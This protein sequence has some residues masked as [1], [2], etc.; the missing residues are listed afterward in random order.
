MNLI[1]VVEHEIKNGGMI[2]SVLAMSNH[3][4]GQFNV[5]LICPPNSFLITEKLNPAITVIP[6]K[7]E[8]QIN[9]GK[10]LSLC[11]LGREIATIVKRYEYTDTLCISNNVGGSIVLSFVRF[12]TK[13]REV[14]INRGGNFREAGFGSKFMRV[15]LRYGNIHHIVA[16]S[17]TQVAVI[18][19]NGFNENKIS[20]IHNGLDIP[21]TEYTVNSLGNKLVIGTIGFISDIKNQ[22]EGVRLIKYLR[23]HGI[24]AYLNIYGS[25]SSASDEIYNV[26]LKKSIS[27][28]NVKPYIN[29]KG[30]VTGEDKFLESDIIISFSK[31]EGF[32][33]TIVEA[34]MRNKPIIAWRG[35]GGP[36]DITENGKYGFLVE[37]NDYHD[38]ATKIFDM[39][40]N[41]EAL[42]QNIEA[43]R[44]FAL[45]NFNTGKMMV[46][47][48]ELFNSLNN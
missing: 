1:F 11:I 12:F 14:Y 42:A 18:K 9:A 48:S 20:L 29:F 40:K 36:I 41:P 19:N 17:T 2:Q 22:I 25:V 33:R 47:Y 35:A 31:T 23:S 27:E 26:K 15:K 7:N 4:A 5:I 45:Q 30:F 8:W 34:M 38:Y 46:K 32:G 28:E 10:I 6:T 3:L 39:Q 24:N 43:S 16:T 21:S 37:H 44:E 13:L